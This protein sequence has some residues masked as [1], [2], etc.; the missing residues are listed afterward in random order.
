MIRGLARFAPD[1]RHLTAC[2]QHIHSRYL[3]DLRWSRKVLAAHKSTA[4]AQLPA[5]PNT[6][7]QA[8][9]RL[10]RLRRRQAVMARTLG[11]SPAQS[12]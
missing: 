12:R 8:S 1:I 10:E 4:A 6:E 9:L 11:I 7:R 5:W 3:P 2:P